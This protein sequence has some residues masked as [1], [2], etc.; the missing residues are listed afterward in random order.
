MRIFRMT[1]ALQQLSIIAEALQKMGAG[2][3][4][5]DPFA[6]TEKGVIQY[7]LFASCHGVSL[8]VR[9]SMPIK[10]SDRWIKLVHLPVVWEV[11]YLAVGPCLRD[12]W[13]DQR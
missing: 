6:T 8:Q 4:T 9:T 5:V 11:A 1:E 10:S 2:P 12:L 7:G 13:E 3:M